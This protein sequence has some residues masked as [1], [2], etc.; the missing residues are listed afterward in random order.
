MQA[1]PSD[2]HGV[3]ARLRLARALQIKAEIQD[4]KVASEEVEKLLTEAE[5]MAR[6]EQMADVRFSRTSYRMRLLKTPNSQQRQQLYDL[7]RSFQSSFPEDK[8][9]ASLLTEVATRFDHEPKRKRE[10]LMDAQPLAKDEELKGR[11]ADDLKR[12]E[13]LGQPVPLRFAP[14]EGKPVDV[15]DYR[16]KAV[17]LVFFAAWSQPAVEALDTI[18]KQVPKLPGDQ[19]QIVGVSLD[20]KSAPLEA[21]VKERKI[22]WPIICDGRGWES[23]LVRSLGINSLPTVWL[24]DREGR[25]VSLDGLESF[26]AQMRDVLTRR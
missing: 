17:A 10:L 16:G 5:R 9:L 12:V 14:P 18:A 2:A 19:M 11:I 25:L 24:L 20:T 15:A 26:S 8:R 1:Y 23:P 13:M 7:A 3:E 21:L 22:G 6:P 4:A